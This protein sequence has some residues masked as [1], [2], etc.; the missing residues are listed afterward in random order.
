ML[1]LLLLCRLYEEE[2]KVK[3]LGITDKDIQI[4]RDK[5]FAC[6]IKDKVSSIS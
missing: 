1:I 5:E 3:H 2:L 4:Y 6:W